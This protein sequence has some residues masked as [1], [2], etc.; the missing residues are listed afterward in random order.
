MG[1]VVGLFIKVSWY[2]NFELNLFLARWENKISL[3][4]KFG[5]PTY[6]NSLRL[7]NP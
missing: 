6:I 1:T 3:K 2:V 4:I 7:K 5:F